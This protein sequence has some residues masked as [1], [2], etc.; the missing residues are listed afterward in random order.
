MG[1]N[2]LHLFEKSRKPERPFKNTANGIEKK[3]AHATQ[4]INI[5]QGV[6]T[7]I[8]YLFENRLHKML[9][10]IKKYS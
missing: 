4:I 3:Q 9:V 7:K 2:K 10:Y 6:L 5:I 8:F 1:S